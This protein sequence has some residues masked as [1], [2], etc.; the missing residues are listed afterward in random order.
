MNRKLLRKFAPIL[1]PAAIALAI[2]PMV[3]Y[4]NYILDLLIKVGLTIILVT[5]LRLGFITGIW[6]AGQT[7]FYAIGAYGLYFLMTGAGI[8]FWPAIPLAGLIASAIAWGLGYVTLRAKGIYFCLIS[9]AF[10]EVIRLTIV[11]TIGSYSSIVAI[12]SPDPIVIPY[13]TTIDFTARVDYYYPMLGLVAISLL[14]LYSL[15][16]SRLGTTFKFIAGSESLAESIGINVLWYETLAFTI[17]AFFA[18]MAGGFFASATMVIDPDCFTVWESILLVFIMIVGGANS[19]L[20]PVIG[21]IV[22]VILPTFLPS[23]PPAWI[24]YATVAIFTLYLLP[25]GLVNLPEVI[26]ARR[27]SLATV[28]K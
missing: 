20:G 3:S 2:P 27:S 18:G 1:I 6:N 5:S 11:N 22:L 13:L 10:V 24:F 16:K 15:E 23:G 17:G 14:F 26:R 4:N 21:A 9:I 19:F 7:A 12:P 8:P 25:N 28:Q